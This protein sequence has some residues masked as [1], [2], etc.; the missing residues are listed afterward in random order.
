MFTIRGT[1]ARANRH[2]NMA[3]KSL[4]DIYLVIISARASELLPEPYRR[5]PRSIL[6]HTIDD[7]TL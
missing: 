3:I 2:Q 1:I 5:A 6:P 4:I 7:P